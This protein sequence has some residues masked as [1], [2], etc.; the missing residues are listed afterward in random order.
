MF[1]LQGVIMSELQDGPEPVHNEDK[2][3][4]IL[5]Y[6]GLFAL[7][8]FFITKSEYV[9]W[10]AR[11]GVT[12]CIASVV[13]WIAVQIVAVIISFIPFLSVLFMGVFSLGML[14]LVIFAIMK[15]LS[16]FRWPIPFVA[17]LAAKLFK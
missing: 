8:P 13:A 15:A 10:H 17:D 7:I 14:A 2:V 5:S 3:M 9:K 16:G 4:L 11:Q 12:L 6:L 1:L